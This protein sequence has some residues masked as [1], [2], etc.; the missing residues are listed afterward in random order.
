MDVASKF[1]NGFYVSN[2]QYSTVICNKFETEAERILKVITKVCN[3]TSRYIK[4]Y[5]F[6]Y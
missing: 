3:I 1:K 5:I 4:V 6:I 2:L